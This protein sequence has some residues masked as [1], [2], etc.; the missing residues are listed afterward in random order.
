M[1]KTEVSHTLG[2]GSAHQA[3]PDGRLGTSGA[4]A[5]EC[6]TR[7]RGLLSASLPRTLVLL[8]PLA[9]LPCGPPI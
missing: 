6:R 2:G 1:R 4:R 9:L 3:L 7:A 8:G 5:V